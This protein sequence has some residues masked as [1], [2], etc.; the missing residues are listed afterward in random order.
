M[1]EWNGDPLVSELKGVNNLGI[2]G[3]VYNFLQVRNSYNTV[4]KIPIPF[5]SGAQ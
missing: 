4:L 5:S 2:V 1:L 3:Y